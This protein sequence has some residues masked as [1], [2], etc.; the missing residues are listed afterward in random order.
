LAL[1]I[2]WMAS[3]FVVVGIIGR[4]AWSDNANS[5]F[6]TLGVFLVESALL[7]ALAGG[8]FGKLAS[9]LRVVRLADGRPP[10]LL[11][12]LL[13]Q[14]AVCLVIPPLVFKPDGRG[15]HDIWSRTKTIVLR[16]AVGRNA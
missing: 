9:G 13:R 1:F 12:A 2:D 10:S 7:T 5:G 16:R 11:P 8:S 14:F 15:L 6:L 3:T 4:D